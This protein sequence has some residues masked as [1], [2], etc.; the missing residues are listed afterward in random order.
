MHHFI[1]DIYFA[2]FQRGMSF[3]DVESV[4][5]F[6]KEYA[7]ETGFSVRIG[8]K[9]FDS[10]GVLKWKR[11][12]VQGQDINQKNKLNSQILLGICAEKGRHDVDVKLIFI[13]SAQVKA[14][15]K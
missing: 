9:R 14:S 11:F 12:C 10:N 3:D 4:E 2:S 15:T 7:H 13:L 1:N 8:Q 5:K 6:Y